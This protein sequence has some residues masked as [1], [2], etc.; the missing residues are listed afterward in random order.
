MS[1]IHI[2]KAIK[3][4]SALILR[5]INE[6]AKYEKAAFEVKVTIED[7]QKTIFGTN[8]TVHALICDNDEE[9]IGFAVYFYNYSTWLGK[10]GL[11][12]E[13]LLV[14]HDYRGK[15]AGKALMKHLAKI[16]VS[17]N[18]C[19]FEWS[20]LDWNEPAIKFY[21]SFSAK[22]QSEWITYRLEDDALRDFAEG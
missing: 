15:G 8:T 10:N 5:F 18:C 13:D 21:E 3:K 16:A 1:K 11:Y 7:I 4:D 14:S 17:E 9:P 2:R 6:L 19:R 12:L 22:S 20:V